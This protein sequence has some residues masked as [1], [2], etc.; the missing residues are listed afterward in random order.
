MNENQEIIRSRNLENKNSL[1]MMLMKEH[2]FIVEFIDY[3]KCKQCGKSLRED[4]ITH[5]CNA[6]VTTFY[7]KKKCGKSDINHMLI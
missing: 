6:K 5:K 1:H 3:V 2:Y 4:N 7:Q